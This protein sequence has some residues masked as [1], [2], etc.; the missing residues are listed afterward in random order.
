MF[1]DSRNICY[2]ST[3]FWKLDEKRTPKQMLPGGIHFVIFC[4]DWPSADT[5]SRA[6]P[7]LYVHRVSSYTMPVFLRKWNKSFKGIHICD[8]N[9][10]IDIKANNFVFKLHSPQPHG[11]N[12]NFVIEI[13]VI[14]NKFN[15]FN[16]FAIET[17]WRRINIHDLLDWLL[18]ILVNWREENLCLQR[19]NWFY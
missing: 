1:V 18:Q 6:V 7:A 14:L 11:Q 5:D 9:I 4:T 17:L 8:D 10:K 2:F 12:R 16:N 3:D 19:E 15:I 13:V